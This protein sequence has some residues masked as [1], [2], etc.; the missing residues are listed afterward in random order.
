MEIH[1]R[2]QSVQQLLYQLS[3]AIPYR[4]LGTSLSVR[5]V[6]SLSYMKEGKQREKVARYHVVSLLRTVKV[7]EQVAI[8]RVL[9]LGRWQEVVTR[10]DEIHGQH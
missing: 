5:I 7:P 10:E 4:N 6:M 8:K 9:R 3:Q 2:L 1:G